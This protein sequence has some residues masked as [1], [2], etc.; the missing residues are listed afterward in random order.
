MNTTV[1]I[2]GADGFIGANLRVRLAAIDGVEVLRVGRGDS[3]QKLAGDAAR[4]DV[5]FHLA[6]VNRPTDLAE[7]ETVNHGLTAT[8]I[9]QLARRESPPAVVLASSTQAAL[10]NP[11]GR[12][13]LAAEQAVLDYAARALAPVAVYRLPGVFGKWSRPD[14]NTVVATFCRNAAE[15]VPLRVDDPDRVLELV[16]IDDVVEEF[17][18]YATGDRAGSAA[19]EIRSI[20]PTFAVSLGELAARIEGLAALRHGAVA[21][22]VG[23]PLTKHLHAM[24]LTFLEPLALVVPM[25]KKTD[26]RGHLFELLKTERSGQVFMSVTHPGVTRGNHYHHD[27][28]ERF[29]VVSGEAR[30]TLRHMITN[31]VSEFLVR[32]EDCQAVDIP[33]GSTHAITNVGD[34]DMVVLFWASENFDPARPD[35]Y[36]EAV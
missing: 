22:D 20:G 6:G 28:V 7:F 12:S 34:E 21:P 19:P 3:I 2:T 23:D 31:E 26:E 25:E 36:F 27:K 14:Y 11:Y 30:I 5:V 13:K 8:L 24:L 35:T 1:L 18:G 4:A 16:H 33:A 10:D 17:A 32:G 15:G 29:F 9:E